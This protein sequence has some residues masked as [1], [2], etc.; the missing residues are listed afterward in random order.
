MV[1]QKRYDYKQLFAPVFARGE[2]MRSPRSFQIDAAKVTS[3]TG[4]DGRLQRL[5]PPG[6][7]AGSTAVAGKVRP[8]P[9]TLLTAALVANTT[10]S[11]TVTANTAPYFVA[12]DVLTA[13][14]P[15]A[16][17]T[18]TGTWAAADTGT[19]TVAGRAITV[20]AANSTNADIAVQIATAINADL[21]LSRIVKAIAS[22]AAVFVY[23]LDMRS[24]Y[25]IAT[26]EV[27]AGNGTLVLGGSATALQVGAAIG[28]I[29]SVAPATHTITLAAAAVTALPIGFPIGVASSRPMDA[30]GEG[31]GM[32]SPNNPIDLEWE[33]N[34]IH[35]LFI[36]GVVYRDRLPYWDGELD[37]LF[38]LLTQA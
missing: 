17:Y 35:G 32:M 21:V 22:G 33:A 16:V 3:S 9:R 12:G 11:F 34:D 19:V 6:T 5:I 23:A 15:Y 26:A 20:E 30:N 7:F 18:V 27:T 29:A 10:L 4:A 24:T 37:A 2:G 8:L 1:L 36:G 31:Y 13:L 25:P 28:T 14:P 38:P